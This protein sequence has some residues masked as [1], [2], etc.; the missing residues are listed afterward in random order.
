MVVYIYALVDPRDGQIK[1][2]GQTINPD[3]RLNSHK[4]HKAT[5]NSGGSYK[6]HWVRELYRLGLT[7]RMELLK[8]VSKEQADEIEKET[9]KAYQEAGHKLVNIVGNKQG[10]K[11]L[12]HVKQLEMFNMFVSERLV[13]R[14]SSKVTLKEL[15]RAYIDWWFSVPDY[16]TSQM[17]KTELF[18][19]LVTQNFITDCTRWHDSITIQGYYIKH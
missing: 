17:N 5:F 18:R 12:R 9:I 6:S 10:L 15:Y 8:E 3:F 7:P 4:K 13:N 11:G 19:V 2:I 16:G 14:K 1:Y